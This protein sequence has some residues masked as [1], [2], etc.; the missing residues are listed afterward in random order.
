MKD[1]NLTLNT[2]ELSQD[3]WFLILLSFMTDFPEKDWN[4][5]FHDLV[6][7]NRF[8]S[9]H[10][11]IDIIKDFSERCTTT[12]KKDQIFYRAR[13]YHQDP[14][15]EFLFD[16]YKDIDT[17]KSS[18]NGFNIDDY[19]YMQ[20]AAIKIAIDKAMPSSKEIVDTYNKWKRKRF[21]GYNSSGSG[22][23]PADSATLGRLNPEKIRYLYLAEDPQTAVYEVRPTI[24]QN[25]SVATFK[26]NDEIKIYD[27]A[28]EIKPQEREIPDY[29][30]TLFSVIQRRFSEPNTGDSFKYLPTQFLGEMI[31]QMGFDGL[32]F[33]SSLKNGGINLV[34]FDDK[35]C[36]VIRSDLIKVSDIVLTF[37]APE[38]Y[39][40]EA[41][42][43]PSESGSD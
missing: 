7:K 33:R 22:A 15:R 17:M 9:S 10:K 25:V 1:E 41:Y 30:H 27:L 5:F 23:P 31:K 37:D 6:Y 16:I 32:R 40:L 29:D 34:L 11:V 4:E 21:K 38:I 20:L 12:I 42:L 18:G 2:E 19:H 36:K 8:S 35:K 28:A 13:I 26:T 39:Q 14:L 24:G 43:K 3:Q